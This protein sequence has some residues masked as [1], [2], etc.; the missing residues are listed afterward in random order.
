[1]QALPD[2]L[3][4]FMQGAINTVHILPFFPYS[5]DR[6]FSIVDYEEVDPR[7][8]TWQDIEE[9][10]DHFRLMFDGVFNHASVEEPAVPA[11]S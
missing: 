6:G 11:R 1:M 9:L 4:T 2:F 7:L 5:S 3:R 10:S 8:G